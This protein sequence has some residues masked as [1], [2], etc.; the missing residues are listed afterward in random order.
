MISRRKA[1]FGMAAMAL[2]SAAS[3]GQDE[4]DWQT[5]LREAIENKDPATLGGRVPP[6]DDPSWREAH[7]VLSSAPSKGTPFGVARYF[8]GSV[9]LK[10]QQA[11]PEP[12]PRHPT[13]AN[14]VIVLFFL[15]TNTNPSGDTT[16]WC[17]A[18]VN[19]CVER[20]GLKGTKSAS[21]QSFA[22][23]NWGKEVWKRGGSEELPVNAKTGDIAIFQRLSDPRLGHVC[24]FSKLSDTQPKSIEVLGGNQILRSG[25]QRLHLID[26]RT[27]GMGGDLKLRSVRTAKGLRYA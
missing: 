4:T 20:V 15:A 25:G 16:A 13:L 23:L 26:V 10:Y 22:D 2:A 1:M 11:W 12:D 3:L 18:F 17:S 7:A 9:P 6:P 21:S 19:W 24:F 14:P 27:L 5:A 8:V